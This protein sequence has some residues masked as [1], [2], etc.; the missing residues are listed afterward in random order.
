MLA[1]GA[2]DC[3]IT[4]YSSKFSLRGEKNTEICELKPVRRL[5]GHGSYITHLDW[6]V[7]N[8]VLQSTCGDYEILFWDIKE[9]KH[10]MAAGAPDVKWGTYTCSLGFPVMGVW[11]PCSD[12]TDI[13]SVD[14]SYQRNLVVIGDD[15]AGV[16]VFNYPCVV[17]DAP[18]LL[19][20]GHS[21]H[22]L[23]VKF[24]SNGD[25]IVSVGGNDKAVILWQLSR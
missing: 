5:K 16:K 18:C 19:C 8:R 12:G 6:S 17:K 3:M 20:S 25:N 11:A 10:W 4:I 24:Y 13:N 22:V 9:G 2:H 15:F 7:D 23:N 21:S 14:V 1:A